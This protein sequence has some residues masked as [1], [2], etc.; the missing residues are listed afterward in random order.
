MAGP[1][2]VSHHAPD[3][4]PSEVTWSAAIDRSILIVSNMFFL[5]YNDVFQ[6]KQYYSCSLLEP[7]IGGPQCRMLILRSGYHN[8]KKHG[9]LNNLMMCFK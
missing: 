5:Y 7:S 6:M 3:C 4:V 1:G 9:F 2:N 8:L